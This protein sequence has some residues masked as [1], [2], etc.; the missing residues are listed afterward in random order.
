MIEN[1]KVEMRNSLKEIDEKTIKKFE[2][3]NKSLVE[4]QES[5]GKTS[6]QTKR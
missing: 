2:E 6:K 1:I 3:I 4:C 5:Q